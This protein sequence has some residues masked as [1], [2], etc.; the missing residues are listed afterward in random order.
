MGKAIRRMRKTL[1]A[2]KL[3]DTAAKRAGNTATES[4]A[5]ANHIN[6]NLKKLKK[7]G[8]VNTFITTIMA[9][10]LKESLQMAVAF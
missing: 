4:I 8:V 9:K 10:S 3:L 7:S 5:Q 6:S 1:I 2:V